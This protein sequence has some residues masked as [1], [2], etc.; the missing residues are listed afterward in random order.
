MQDGLSWTIVRFTIKESQQLH[1]FRI[2]KVDTKH[3]D[4]SVL[5]N[6]VYKKIQK[7]MIYRKRL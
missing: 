5:Q 2:F 4:N 1:E 7:Y 6:I 3:I